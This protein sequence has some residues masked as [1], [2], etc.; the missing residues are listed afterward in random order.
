[1]SMTDGEWPGTLRH[2]E[3][4]GSDT[5]ALCG[6]RRPRSGH[7]SRTGRNQHFRRRADISDSA[8]KRGAQV[9]ER[10]PNLAAATAQASRGPMRK[11]RSARRHDSCHAGG[12]KRSAVVFRLNMHAKHI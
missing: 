4:L 9:P 2:V 1:M 11:W 5:I 10:T 3:H 6:W 12:L 8:K 7:G